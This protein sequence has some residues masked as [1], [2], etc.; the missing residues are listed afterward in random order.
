[1]ATYL[2]LNQNNI[3]VNAIE[4]DGVSEYPLEEAWS[5]V[6]FDEEARPWIGWE[7][8]N[9]DWI[10][11]ETTVNEAN[12]IKVSAREKLLVLGLSDDE[13]NALLGV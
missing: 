3:V 4:Y 8:N 1:M 10:K 9:G 11:P 2:L 12:S 13:I 5:L 7:L 6:P